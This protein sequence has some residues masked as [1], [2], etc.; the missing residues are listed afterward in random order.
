MAERPG[1][2]YP[3]LLGSRAIV[4]V[5]CNTL[6]D[7][8]H[9]GHGVRSIA[10]IGPNR[11]STQTGRASMTVEDLDK[12]YFFHPFTNLRSHEESGP[13]TMVEWP[14]H[15][16]G[17]HA[18]A[19]V[20]RRHGGALVR[21]RRLRQQEIA[22]TL[23]AQ[24]EKLGLLPL[25]LVDEQRSLST[26]LSQRL[27]TMAPGRCQRCSSASAAPTP[28]TP[29]SSWSGTTTTSSAGPDKK[30]IISRLPRLSRR[31]RA[32]RQPYRPGQLHAA[33]TCRCR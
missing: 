28:T 16:A 25:V 20:P 11:R 9:A 3:A 17:R 6:L 13:L 4:R 21:E 2:A 12:E 1:S 26:L 30:K 32:V 27:V 22:E 23:R 14:R 24:A 15:H 10:V 18:R 5:P 19:R 8:P 29:R 7:S 33:S 31:D